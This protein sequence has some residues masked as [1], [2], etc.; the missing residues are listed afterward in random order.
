ME[1]NESLF[2]KIKSKYII[3]KICYY[4]KDENILRKLLFYS[5]SLQGK[6]NITLFDYQK[7][8][9]NKRMKWEDYI[10]Y[11][12]SSYKD[13]NKDNLKNKLK[14]DLENINPIDNN[15]IQKIVIDYFRNKKYKNKYSER[16]DIYSPFFDLLS[17]TEFFNNFTIYIS[18]VMIEECKLEKE[19]ISKF[20]EL[21][22]A[23]IN[24]SSN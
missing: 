2:T 11:D 21:N 5:K 16:I 10:Y 14:K 7:N 4:I 13:F 15:T 17:K 9:V 22:N 12:Y 24:Y 1:T 3:N 20:H 19:Y 8:Y 23:N 6:I 18:M